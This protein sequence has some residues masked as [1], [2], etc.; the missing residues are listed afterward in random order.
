MENLEN[1][2]TAKKTKEAAMVEA[3]ADVATE[4]GAKKKPHVNDIAE[5][6]AL[7]EKYMPFATSIASKMAR[8]MPS[9]VDFDD[10]VCN[11][12]L[13]LLEAAKRYDARFGVDFKTFAY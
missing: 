1:L 13:G 10:L 6:D 7:I 3:T 5:R 8:T 11:A 4:E 2:E 9:S 12:R